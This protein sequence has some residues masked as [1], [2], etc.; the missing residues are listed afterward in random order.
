C[1]ASSLSSSCRCW[2]P[3]SPGWAVGRSA[4]PPP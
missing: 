2:P 4:T 3:S 1:R